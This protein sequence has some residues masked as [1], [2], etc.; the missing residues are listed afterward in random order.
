MPENPIEMSPPPPKHQPDEIRT[1]KE[2][3]GIELKA[4][5]FFPEDLPGTGERTVFVFFHPGGWEMGEPAW[6]YDIS[7]RYAAAGLIA[8]SFQYRLSAKGRF[9]PAEA[10]SDACSAVGWTRRHAAELGIDPNR[11][12]AGGISAGGHLAACAAVLPRP[13]DADVRTAPDALA[14]QSAPVN[15]ALDSH[16]VDLLQGREKPETYSPAHH[17]RPGLPPMC[18]I[19]GTA[20]EI[21]PYDSV[22]DFAVRMREAGNRCDLHPFEGTDHFFMKNPNPSRITELIDDFLSGL[23]YMGKPGRG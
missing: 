9:T 23:G 19:H 12:V 16:F 8:I 15:P 13:D 3:K 14:L 21:V 22:Q 6:M 7:H 18:L 5:F 10:V 11:I 1:Y 2:V 20:D 4:H 17:V